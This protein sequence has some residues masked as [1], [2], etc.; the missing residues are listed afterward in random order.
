L[1]NNTRQQAEYAEE[2]IKHICGTFGKREP[3]S[4]A[5]RDAQEYL[6]GEITKNGW[7]DDVELQGFKVAP[8]AFLIFTKL[9]TIFMLFGV[10][11]FILHPAA[12][13]VA[14][15]LSLT[16]FLTHMIF[17][18]RV[19][20]FLCK[21]SPSLNLYAAKKPTGEVKRRIIFGGHTDAAYEMTLNHKLGATRGKLVPIISIVGMLV[22]L[23][24]AIAATVLM[25]NSAMTEIIK[26][27]F[28]GVAAAFTPF[29][30]GTFYYIN[31]RK[32]VD[33]ANDN[34][35]AT[36]VSIAVL[37]HMHENGISFENTEVCALSSGAEEAGLRGAKAFVKQNLPMLK[38]PSVETVFIALETLR[39]MEHFSV[40]K[41][42]LNSLVKLNTKAVKL[43]EDAIKQNDIPL[44]YT[45]VPLGATDAA[46]FAKKGIPAVGI[47]AMEHTPATFYHTRLDSADNLC[48]TCLQKTLDVCLTALDTF[49]KQGL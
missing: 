4:K 17:Y 10:G 25:T 32:V 19:F 27:S 35:S 20:G 47:L 8:K 14:V 6:A 41:R 30:I 43:M 7:A 49:D 36:L 46:A 44:Q 33:G 40:I 11:F 3:G 18:C 29:H 45:S 37:K 21:R 42:D 2:Q 48:L 23:G 5:E 24:L 13:I 12:L 15:L 38:D 31:F 1:D 28:F 39:Q 16:A 9:I 34:L 22:S 26:W